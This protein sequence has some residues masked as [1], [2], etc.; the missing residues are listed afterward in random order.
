MLVYIYRW[1]KPT[2]DG[3]A[4]LSAALSLTLGTCALSTFLFAHRYNTV[5]LH[6]VNRLRDQGA[7]IPCGACMPMMNLLLADVLALLLLLEAGALAA[8]D[9]WT[10]CTLCIMS[11]P[12]MP[13]ILT[14]YHRRPVDLEQVMVLSFG[15]LAAVFVLSLLLP[16]DPAAWAL[17]SQLYIAHDEDWLSLEEFEEE[18]PRLPP[19][20]PLQQF[21]G[22]MGRWMDDRTPVMPVTPDR[23]TDDENADW[24]PPQSPTAGLTEREQRELCARAAEARLN[25]RVRRL[26]EPD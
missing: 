23:S 2:V 3:A 22:G 15:T 19:A 17:A 9:W 18:P 16:G 8:F 4:W 24:G 6:L 1:T 21:Q 7:I 25:P 20:D 10:L 13:S 26:E 5:S 11:T 12:S 14:Q